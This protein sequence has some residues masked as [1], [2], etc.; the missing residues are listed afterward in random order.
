MVASSDPS[1]NLVLFGRVTLARNALQARLM[2]LK[3]AHVDAQ[4]A[5][6]EVE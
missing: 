3:L 2:A 6:G 5:E 4:A 1:A